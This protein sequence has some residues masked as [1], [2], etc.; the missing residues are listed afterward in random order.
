MD[1]E[2]TVNDRTIEMHLNG[3]GADKNYADGERT[4]ET[5]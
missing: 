1:G 5:V 3:G 4:R 2:N